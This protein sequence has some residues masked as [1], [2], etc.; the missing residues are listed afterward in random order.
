MPEVYLSLRQVE[1]HLGL[2]RGGAAKYR[3]PEPDVVI[4][5][6]NDDGTFPRG[7]SRGWRVETIDAWNARR[8]GHGGRPPKSHDG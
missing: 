6:V 1:E 5:A 3:L 4:G 7:T 8:P 2:A